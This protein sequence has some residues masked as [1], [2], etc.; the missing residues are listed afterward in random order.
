MAQALKQLGGGLLLG[1]L[2]VVI[3][4]GAMSL[5][6]AEENAPQP[7]TSPLPTLTPFILPSLTSP[8]TES[9]PA[10]SATSIPVTATLAS[11][12]APA[13]TYTSS[14]IPPT[15]CTPP[16]GWILVMIQSGDTLDSIAY[17]HHTTT[18]ALISANCLAS[19]NLQPGYGIYAPP[20]PVY[21]PFVCHA[22]YG[23]VQYTVI[24]G[25][26][27]YHIS[28][29]YRITVT[30][31]KHANCLVSD[32]IAVGQ[33]LWV[34]NT[35]TSTP[36]A[37]IINIEFDTVTPELTNTSTPTATATSTPTATATSTPTATPTATGTATTTN[38]PPTPQ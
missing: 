35:F 31:L 7:T 36:P 15:A 26:T 38:T 37:T 8:V 10:V 33:R 19:T 5:A 21:T 20:I 11:L 9:V 32:F 1:L 34:P 23:W 2:S 30:D 3:I 29:L 4:I 17:R 27:L 18:G 12:A 22:P 14:P 13:A 28:Q 6:L 24:P 25:D 16:S